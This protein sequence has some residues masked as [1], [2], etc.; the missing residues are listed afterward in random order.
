MSLFNVFKDMKTAFR[1]V[2]ANG[3]GFIT[4]DELTVVIKNLGI[5]CSST[6]IEM[7]ITDADTDKDG[8]I[9]WDEFKIMVAE[10]NETTNV[11]TAEEDR[12]V[13]NLKNFVYFRKQMFF[14]TI[15]SGSFG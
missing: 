8:R 12:S 3:D 15:V 6:D 10:D 7:M 13:E 5:L 1:A 2:D 4:K 9:C 11:E 14:A